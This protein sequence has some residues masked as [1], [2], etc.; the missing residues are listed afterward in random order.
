MRCIANAAAAV[1]Y[2]EYRVMPLGYRNPRDGVRE[3][4]C[5][6]IGWKLE[7]PR[8][9]KVIVAKHPILVYGGQ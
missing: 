8:N 5:T 9:L 6:A 2:R 1:A 7:L 4:Q 3:S